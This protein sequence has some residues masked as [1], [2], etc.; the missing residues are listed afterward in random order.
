[1]YTVK[2]LILREPLVK[3][4]PPTIQWL[5]AFAAANKLVE[6]YLDIALFACS[7]R[8]LR[9]TEAGR[10]IQSKAPKSLV[11]ADLQRRF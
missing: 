2:A 10:Q 3:L 9:L 1:M 7:E 4:K 5:P 6:E 11:T 8:K